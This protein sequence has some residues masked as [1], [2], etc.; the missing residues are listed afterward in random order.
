MLDIC[1]RRTDFGF[2]DNTCAFTTTAL[3][4]GFVASFVQGKH[5]SQQSLTLEI[6]GSKRSGRLY[7]KYS[8]AGKFQDTVRVMLTDIER[9]QLILG[10]VS[11]QAMSQADMYRAGTVIEITSYD[12][13]P[14]LVADEEEDEWSVAILIKKATFVR[15]TDVIVDNLEPA[16]MT[17]KEDYQNEQAESSTAS[18][19]DS[20]A[21]GTFDYSRCSVPELLATQKLDMSVGIDNCRCEGDCST[22]GVWFPDCVLKC[23]KWPQIE[24]IQMNCYFAE[25]STDNMTNKE[26]RNILYWWTAV[27]VYSIRGRGLRQELPSCVVTYVR[28]RFPED[29]DSKY[30]GFRIAGNESR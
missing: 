10:F 27:N 1:A 6:Y 2:D 12:R 18:H 15:S 3:T 30:T 23:V 9:K 17:S 20:V 24:D 22:Y 21:T 8:A 7:G 19:S 11:T 16:L 5:V 28:N 25:K 14:H 4:E 13:I 29:D 26:K